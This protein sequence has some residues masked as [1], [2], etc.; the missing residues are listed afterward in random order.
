MCSCKKKT[1]YLPVIETGFI[2]D[3]VLPDSYFL[4][5]N[6]CKECHQ[7]EFKLWQGSHHDKAMQL[8]DS[9]S[10]LADFK[11]EK[12]TSQGVTSYFYKKEGEF[13][14]NTEGP[15]GN[16]HDYKIIYTFGITPLQQYIVKFPNGHYQCL[17]TAWDSVE[18]KWFDLYP[19]FK[20]VHSEWLHWSRGGLNWNNMCADCHS[21]NV[22]KNYDFE[23]ES[24]DTKYSLINV[25]CEA[26]HGPGKQHVEDVN[27]LGDA[28]KDSGT[29]KMTLNTNPRN[30]VD[31]CARC[32]MRREQFSANYN[33]EGTMLD[34]YF[35]QLIQENL[36]HPDGQI[37]DEVYV[38]GSFIQSKMY[39]NN[40]SCNN[41][42]DSHSLKLRFEGNKLCAQC[43]LTETYDTP[44]HHFHEMN[45][46][47][48][49]CINCHMTGKYYM[50]NDFRRDHSFRVPR[51]DLSLKYDSPNACTGCHEDKDD[52]WAWAEFQKQYGEVDSLHFSDKLAP[53]IT[54]QPGAHTGLIELINDKNQPEIVR[55][56]ATR[57]LSNY[58]TLNFIDQYLALLE[59]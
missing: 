34:H 17:R 28:Y 15:D 56:S 35:P 18:N 53:G 44:K 20:V 40:V 54:R 51:P 29:L 24:Y 41:C 50:G 45:T 52:K 59:R 2:S 58:N 21:T 57:T 48:A 42:H 37:L 47:G 25:N 8:A 55:A 10:V 31:Q 26:C 12:F 13:Y 3:Q 32:H 5:D 14:V 49:Q 11:G 6:N 33:Y 19:D 38:Y 30:L 1:E 46:E 36:Y 27:R 16:Y 43:H 9:I 22:R 4:G 7:E 39:K 23:T